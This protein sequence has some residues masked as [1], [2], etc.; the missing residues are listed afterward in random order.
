VIFGVWVA[1]CAS[2]MVMGYKGNA[3]RRHPLNLPPCA[4]AHPCYRCAIPL[5]R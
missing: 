3:A 1:V 5:F 4:R 2:I